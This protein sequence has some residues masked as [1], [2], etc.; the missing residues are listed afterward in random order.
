MPTKRLPVDAVEHK[1]KYRRNK[2]FFTK[3]VDKNEYPNWYVT[4]IFFSVYHM[5]CAYYYKI[6]ETIPR[7]GQDLR[8]I[9]DLRGIKSEIQFLEKKVRIVLYGG[10]DVKARDI[11]DAKDIFEVVESCMLKKIS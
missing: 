10:L 3:G 9:D 8:I 5:I 11:G 7:S 1:K 4:A 6:G 2:D